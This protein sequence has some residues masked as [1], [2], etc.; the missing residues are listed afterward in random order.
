VLRPMM[1]FGLKWTHF[2]T[3]CVLYVWPYVYLSLTWTR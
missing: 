3:S 2:Y 1:Q